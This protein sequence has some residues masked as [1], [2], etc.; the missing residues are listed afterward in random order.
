MPRRPRA[1]PLAA[2]LLSAAVVCLL[3]EVLERR[4]GLVSRAG[5]LAREKVE[6]VARRK[7]V[8]LAAPDVVKAPRRAA[9][10]EKSPVPTPAAPAAAEPEPAPARPAES[11]GLLDAMRQARERT[12][13]RREG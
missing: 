10:P 8:R 7:R 2:W 1:F 9:V 11:G 12:R 4:T 3:M 5:R 13:E 6:K